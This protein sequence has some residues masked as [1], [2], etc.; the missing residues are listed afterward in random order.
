[1]RT[2][3]HPLIRHFEEIQDEDNCRYPTSSELLSVGSNFSKAFGF[4][5]IGVHHE[6]LPPGRRTSF[7]H[8]ESSE[9]E[10]VYVIEG[11]PDVWIDGEIFR[12]SPG[13]GVGFRPGTGIAHTFINNS[14]G[15]VRLL[16]VGEANKPENK[17]YYPLNP[18]MQKYRE[19]SWWQDVPKRRLGPHS[20]RPNRAKSVDEGQL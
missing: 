8:A 3:G 6:H 19:D 10:F 1:M 17:I 16:V 9:E 13:D 18:E 12:L 2:T 5:K 11:H 20:G 14:E 7:P 4:Q 15:V